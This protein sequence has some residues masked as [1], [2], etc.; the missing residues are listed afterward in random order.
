MD[1][2]FW[3]GLAV[4]VPLSVF[5]NMITPIAQRWWEKRS[6][7][8]AL[9]ITSSLK[10]EYD[11]VKRY[12]LERSLFHEY[13][14][15]TIIRTTVTGSLAAFAVNVASTAGNFLGGNF[16]FYSVGNMISILGALVIVQVCMRAIRIYGRLRNFDDYQSFVF[17]ELMIEGAESTTTSS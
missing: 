6:R 5:A 10:A 17:K 4:S 15:L 16:L 14:L 1:Y 3:I 9:R 12:K 13:L 8:N 2:W 11:E 7:T